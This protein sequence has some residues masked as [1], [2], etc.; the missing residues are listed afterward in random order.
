M[1]YY[2]MNEIDEFLSLLKLGDMKLYS[3]KKKKF[4]NIPF[5][6]DIETTNAYKNINTGE[7]VEANIIVKKKESDT[8][9]QIEEWEKISWMYVWQAS[10]NDILFMGRTWKE[11][12]DFIKALIEK[13]HLSDHKFLICYVR[14]L[15]FEFQYIKKYFN[16]IQ[17]FAAEAHKVI[18]AR[19]SEGIE[20]RCSYFLAG[21]SLETTGKNLIKY[22][23][24]KQVG[25]LDYS[26]LRNSKTPL[27]DDEID[28]CLYDVIVDSNF[29]KESMEDEPKNSL[30]KMPLTKTGY[31]RRY[32]RNY[33]QKARMHKIY[34]KL[35]HEFTM[36]SDKYE[37]LKRTFA[38]GFTHSNALNTGIVFENVKSQDI[39][40][41][42]PASMAL[43]P[44]FPISK[45]RRYKPKSYQDFLN[46]LKIYA[47]I[48][49]IEFIDIKMRDDVYE[50]IISESKCFDIKNA[51]T[52]NGRVV[53]ADSL[54]I[55]I[56]EID[57]ECIKQFYSFKRVK[58]SN[59]WIYRRGYLPK[60]LIECVIHFFL[61]K[62]TL[63]D[64]EGKEKEYMI[65]KG[66]LNSIFG[67]MVTDP[68]HP[69]ITFENYEW[70]VNISKINDLLERYNK[71]WNRFLVYEWGLFTTSL[72]R[73]NV[74]AGIKNLKED[75]IYCDT[76]SLKYTN[77]EKHAAW[78]EKYNNN[79]LK[80][81]DAVCEFYHFDKK[82]FMPQDIKGKTHILGQFTDE[83]NYKRFKTLGAK[84]YLYEN[85][86]GVNLTVSGLN[87]VDAIPYLLKQENQLKTDIFDLFDDEMYIP[88]GHSGKLLH[89]YIDDVKECDCIDYLGNKE[90]IKCESAVH[91]EPSSYSLSLADKYKNYLNKIKTKYKRGD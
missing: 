2:T 9:F 81:I 77:P 31:V 47:C 73:K 82:D 75:Y 68:I 8:H 45:G 22:Q 34:S 15:E 62:T 12:F 60:E 21:C 57:F 86:K 71:Q 87:K 43:E 32:V 24:T 78:F 89:T 79:I 3:K 19:C 61:N 54:S 29:I 80:K 74:L 1:K 65:L 26:K 64:V 85:E 30:L 28:Y 91:L 69:E 44:R 67:M 7:V 49:D 50:N 27:T 53:S 63:K 51:K 42:Y 88:C 6:F 36:D 10:I 5:T 35:V 52:N 20:F 39:T 13:F 33:T 48:F 46:K 17:V 84:R 25:K 55:S 90:H 18:Y 40:S 37:L 11:F 59:M 83:G 58:I 23:A 38:G 56:T 72:S 14:N 66:M 16:W 41:S 70:G 76:D 4:W